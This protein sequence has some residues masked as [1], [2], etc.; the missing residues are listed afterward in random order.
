MLHIVPTTALRPPPFVVG[1]LLEAY[2]CD[3][4]T[5]LVPGTDSESVLVRKLLAG[6]RAQLSAQR[7]RSWVTTTA[8]EAQ[9]LGVDPEHWMRLAEVVQ[10]M[11][12]CEFTTDVENR[13]YLRLV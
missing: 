13:L 12:L 10:G 9:S 6:L 4:L 7:S 3:E 8:Y 1:P 2:R 11:G 5:E